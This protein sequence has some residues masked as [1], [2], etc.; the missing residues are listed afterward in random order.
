MAPP[1]DT[2]KPP[3]FTT[4]SYI[5][6]FILILGLGK[7]LLHSLSQILDLDIRVDII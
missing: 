7:H 6:C 5:V 4:D 1:A 2:L 3:P